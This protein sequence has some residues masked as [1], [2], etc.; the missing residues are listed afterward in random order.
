M[1]EQAGA[2]SR[3][4]VLCCGHNDDF[5]EQRLRHKDWATVHR[6]VYVNH[7]GP[8]TWIQRLW[9]GLLFAWPAAADAESALAL[10]G[11][12]TG[13]TPD[14]IH[15]VITPDRRVREP[16]GVRVR[17]MRRLRDE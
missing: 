8:L 5:I 13:S 2:G 7:T 12:R 14:D 9:A 15:V 17:T 4:Q 3:G 10:H 11:L 1:S 16:A 6:G